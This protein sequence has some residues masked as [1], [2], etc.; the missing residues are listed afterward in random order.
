MSNIFTSSI[1][2]KFWMA[3]IGLFLCVFLVLHMSIN[4]LLLLDDRSYFDTAVHIMSSAPV[5]ILEIFL[6]GSIALHMF[7]GL[8]LQIKNWLARP[9]RYAKKH[10][11]ENSFFS[12]YM[13]WTGGIIFIFF[14]IHFMH[15]F[16]YKM[17]WFGRIPEAIG[18]GEYTNVETGA[19]TEAIHNFYDISRVVFGSTCYCVMYVVFMALLSFHLFHAFQSVFQSLGWNHPTYTPIV[20]WIG[21]IYAVVI[22]LGFAI[23]PLYFLFG[24]K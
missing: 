1:G 10:S 23:I 4:L 12:K 7:L 9:V 18:V 15:F 21:N 20:K 22:P 2:K 14:C 3:L 24:G 5:K 8:L 19:V 11:S 16:F 6:F 17:Q 13:I